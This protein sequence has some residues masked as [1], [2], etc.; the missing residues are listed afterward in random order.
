MHSNQFIL[1]FDVE[2]YSRDLQY[3]QTDIFRQPGFT[4]LR[5][6]KL[7]EQN[8]HRTVRTVCSE[9]IVHFD[10]TR[11]DGLGRIPFLMDPADSALYMSAEPWFKAP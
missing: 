5:T 9:R 8:E 6:S 4:E 7:D 3:P 10:R 2:K 1:K 11:P